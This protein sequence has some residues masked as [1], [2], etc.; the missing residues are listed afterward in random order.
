MIL[1][2]TGTAE[3]SMAEPSLAT[4]SQNAMFP[5]WA[6]FVYRAVGVRNSM[7][8]WFMFSHWTYRNAV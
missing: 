5:I 7:R 6:A 4:S 3:S 2:E 1:P 8:A